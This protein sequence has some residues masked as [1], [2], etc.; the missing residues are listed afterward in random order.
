M[1]I[2]NTKMNATAAD[3]PKDVNMIKRMVLKVDKKKKI[4]SEKPQPKAEPNTFADLNLRERFVEEKKSMDGS[5]IFQ[6]TE[7][8]TFSIPPFLEPDYRK[9]DIMSKR[10][11]SVGVSI[12]DYYDDSGQVIGSG[13]SGQVI[14]VINKITKE[15][16]AYKQFKFRGHSQKQLKCLYNE[17]DLF[18]GMSHPNVAGLI[19]IFSDSDGFGMVMELCIGGNL[20]HYRLKNKSNWNETL[21]KHL[22]FQMLLAVHSQHENSIA[23]RDI[24]LDNFVV[25]LNTS[26][27]ENLPPAEKIQRLRAKLIDF[28]ISRR[29]KQGVPMATRQGTLEYM[30]P[31]VFHSI[32]DTKSDM[33]SLGVCLFAL[34]FAKFPYERSKILNGHVKAIQYG[35]DRDFPDE[36]GAEAKDLLAHLL[37]Y[38]PDI[39]PNTLEALNHPWLAAEME[40]FEKSYTGLYNSDGTT[41]DQG[42]RMTEIIKGFFNC[43]PFTRALCAYMSRYLSADFR[44]RYDLIFLAL[45][46]GMDEIKLVDNKSMENFPNGISGLRD[47]IPA[48]VDSAANSSAPIRS[49]G[50]FDYLA[51]MMLAEHHLEQLER[52]VILMVRT[53][54]AG[55]KESISNKRNPNRTCVSKEEWTTFFGSTIL[56]V[57]CSTEFDNLLSQHPDKEETEKLDVQQLL[58][59][60]R[61]NVLEG[62]TATQHE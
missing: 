35:V 16:Y 54:R 10:I 53:F 39:R 41:T 33:W 11:M 25:Q 51:A 19:E 29:V 12:W 55:K 26:L 24:K 60:E 4:P 14:C 34:M 30:A 8:E 28:G 31:E 62:L 20:V 22:F 46:Q 5:L 40:V 2:S 21:T 59:S 44:N 52:F 23:I 6:N 57:D 36:I 47:M 61:N 49:I 17:M 42:Y 15:K 45:T 7:L 43:H 37:A 32:Y 48:G 56:G 27:D 50:W 38:N 9:N 58:K 13:L 3:S 18:L 1:G